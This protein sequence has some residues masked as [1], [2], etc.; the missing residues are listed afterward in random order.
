MA[1]T[2]EE[3]DL[4]SAQEEARIRGVLSTYGIPEATLAL[5]PESELALYATA[6]EYVPDDADFRDYVK[7]CPDGE[8]PLQEEYNDLAFHEYA[9]VLAE[10]K[11]A[12]T[13]RILYHLD[14]RE[15][16]PH[17]YRRRL[18]IRPRGAA[19]AH[20]LTSYGQ[21]LPSD[22]DPAFLRIRYRRGDTVYDCKPFYFQEKSYAR[23]SVQSII[24]YA[25]RGCADLIFAATYRVTTS[26]LDPIVHFGCDFICKR[27]VRPVQL[28]PKLMSESEFGEGAAASGSIYDRRYL[29]GAATQTKE[30]SYHCWKSPDLRNGGVFFTEEN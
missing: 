17:S 14:Y 7:R 1:Q 22:S 28:W 20:A 3:T 27:F 26:P 21:I 16:D 12:F 30:T 5:L 6:K 23:G 11:D 2:V 25:E 19:S 18:E 13:V 24:E 29:N 4:L 9:V 15:N 8:Y 10:G